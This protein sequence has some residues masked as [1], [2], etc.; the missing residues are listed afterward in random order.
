V[1]AGTLG[2]FDGRASTLEPLPPK[3]RAQRYRDA[4]AESQSLEDQA[5]Q[6]LT[7]ADY[8]WAAELGQLWLDAEPDNRQA[9]NL[10][11]EALEALGRGHINANAANWYLTEALEHRGELTV[12]P[13]A[14]DRVPVAFIDDLP[15]DAF[16]RA[17]ST[18]LKAED[19]LHVDWVAVFNFTDIDMHYVLHIRRG[20]AEMRPRPVAV[21][22]AMTPDLRL[23]TTA[24]TWKRIASGHVGA[25]AAMARGDLRIDGGLPQ[26]VKL[27][28]WIE[29]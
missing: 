7:D 4:F 9:G 22:V 15:V 23:T 1:Y 6:A 26:L 16:M 8:A 29:R 25:P 12:K 17:L 13:S 11:A 27:Q 24:I 28:R 14:P 18:R 2:W 19:T 5:R 3:D 10:L 20:V 21:T